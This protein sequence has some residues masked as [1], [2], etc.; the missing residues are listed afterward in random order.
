MM[1]HLNQKGFTLI[2]VLIASFIMFISIAAF[3][4]VF[5]SSILSSEKAEE[6]VSN[7]A[8]VEVIF[9]EI[10]GVLFQHKNSSELQGSGNLFGMRYTWQAKVIDSTRPPARYF[11]D[12][13]TQADHLAKI[14]LIELSVSYNQKVSEYQY[15]E[16]TW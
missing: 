4:L 6:N 7:S 8:Y 13:L 15:Q 5:R 14:W 1:I 16:V 12:T 3:T 10:S 11:G 9:G 2:E